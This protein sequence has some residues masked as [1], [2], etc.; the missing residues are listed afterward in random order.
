MLLQ[1]VSW[2]P[3]R[4]LHSGVV[5]CPVQ[6]NSAKYIPVLIVGPSR[7]FF[8]C[9]FSLVLP[10]HTTLCLIP[11]I[12]LHRPIL[13]QSQHNYA[14]EAA[15]I[16][17]KSTP[18]DLIAQAAANGYR[19]GEHKNYDEIRHCEK[20]VKKTENDQVAILKRYVI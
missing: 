19:R 16:N 3:I 1:V 6:S 8:W 17:Q 20:H 7:L 18:D 15:I 9:F 14:L 4:P 11:S 10:P 2:L 13:F 12:S 5:I